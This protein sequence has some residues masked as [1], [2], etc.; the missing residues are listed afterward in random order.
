MKTPRSIYLAA[1]EPILL[2]A[3]WSLQ[4]LA[5]DLAYNRHS[6]TA[7]WMNKWLN[8]NVRS[9][10]FCKLLP[11]Q[12]QSQHQGSVWKKLRGTDPFYYHHSLPNSLLFL[13][14]GS[15]IYPWLTARHWLRYN[16]TG[17][18]NCI[19]TSDQFRFSQNQLAKERGR[20]FIADWSSGDELW[21]EQGSLGSSWAFLSW[22]SMSRHL[23]IHE[24]MHTWVV[25]K[26]TKSSYMNRLESSWKIA[27]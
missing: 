6:K 20:N 18:R 14:S 12:S 22:V 5:W 4:C 26:K 8:W 13:F 3:P 17:L 24:G 25:K 2:I 7:G 19:F 21:A 10:L 9:G 1:N 15:D 23:H 27:L 11:L 16:C